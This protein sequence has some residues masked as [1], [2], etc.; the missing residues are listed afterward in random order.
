MHED[1][2]SR[3]KSPALNLKGGAA[4]SYKSKKIWALNLLSQQNDRVESNLNSVNLETVVT[5]DLANSWPGT[6]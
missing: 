1:L 6:K 5:A 2:G 3:Y 4:V